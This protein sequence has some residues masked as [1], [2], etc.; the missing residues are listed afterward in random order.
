[1]AL[2][3]QVERAEG[4]CGGGVQ[5][6]RA[7][8][9]DAAGAARDLADRLDVSGDPG[10]A[11]GGALLALQRGSVELAAGCDLGSDGFHRL[12]AQRACGLGGGIQELDE[13][14]QA[15]RGGGGQAF[16]DGH[17]FGSPFQGRTKAATEPCAGAK[18]KSEVE[19]RL[20]KAPPEFPARRI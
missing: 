15:G 8:E 19:A 14:R 18:V 6:L 10:Q 7:V 5:V 20:P 13:I 3:L 12:L 16:S 17:G 2:R 9:R 1:M 11:M 4:G